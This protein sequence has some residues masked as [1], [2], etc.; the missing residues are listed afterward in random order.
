MEPRFGHD[1]Q[2][3]RIHTGP[4][5]SESAQAVSALAYTVG[6]D[7]VFADG[8]YNPA[9]HEGQHLLAHELAH[10]VQQAGASPGLVSGIGSPGDA[11]ERE[12]DSV[13]DQVMRMPD[14]ELSMPQADA[15]ADHIVRGSGAP[16]PD[17]LPG[18][19][20]QRMCS[21]CAGED[22]EKG[23]PRAQAVQAPDLEEDGVDADYPPVR[24]PGEALEEEQPQSPLVRSIGMMQRAHAG[25]PVAA[26]ALPATLAEH[27]RSPAAA[28]LALQPRAGAAGVLQRWEVGGPSNPA[29]NTIV[30]DGSGGIRVQMS[31][32]NDAAAFACVGDCIIRHEQSHR[33]DALASNADVCKGSK[34]GTQVNMSSVAEQKP[35]EIKASQ[36]EIDCLNAKKPTASKECKPII[37]GRITQMI[38]Y[39]DSFK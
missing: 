4:K 29:L 9:S 36:V 28:A 8:K 33:A 22:K 15:I 7:I 2:H 14:P 39:R 23:A 24:P 26:G 30:C 20:L 6:Q 18:T 19:H 16:S 37:D 12:A 25:G 21:Q 13:S 27:P 11:S 5:A 1:F 38:A 35:S 10:T 31:N 3:V 34:D 32:A 17:A